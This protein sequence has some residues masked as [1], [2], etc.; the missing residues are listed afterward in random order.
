MV[1]PPPEVLKAQAEFDRK[2]KRD[3]RFRLELLRAGLKHYR[4]TGSQRARDTR[5]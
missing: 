4:D 1:T 3:P 5:H 2:L